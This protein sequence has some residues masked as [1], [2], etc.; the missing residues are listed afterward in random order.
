MQVITETVQFKADQKLL[1][2]T[3]KR[4]AK[5]EQYFERIVEARVFL[6]LENA[7]QVKDKVAE[8]RL[9]VPGQTL[10]ATGTDKTFEAAVDQAASS[11]RRQLARYKEK[12]RSH[13]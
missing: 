5:L 3:E 13:G 10:F 7:G 2:Y 4:L 1:D 11:L 8:V 6:K 12:I 9:N